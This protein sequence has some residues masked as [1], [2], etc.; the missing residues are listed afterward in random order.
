MEEEL[1]ITSDDVHDITV[2]KDEVFMIKQKK[3]AE[4]S[5]RPIARAPYPVISTPL[6]QPKEPRSSSASASAMEKGKR[7][8][9]RGTKK[10]AKI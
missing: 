3:I 7:K 8:I 5:N 2:D 6:S 1:D 9:T 10:G 4:T